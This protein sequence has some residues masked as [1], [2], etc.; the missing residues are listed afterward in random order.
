MTSLAEL[1]AD[2]WFPFTGS[3]EVKPLDP[4]VVPEPLRHGV[5]GVDCDGCSKPDE[6]FV[7]T[8]ERWRLS[9]YRESPFPGVVLLNTRAHFDSYADLTDDLLAELGPLTARVERAVLSIGDVARVHVARWGDG[10]EHFHQWFL[11]RPLGMLQARG[12]MLPMWLDLLPPLPPEAIDAALAQIAA[13]M[14]AS[15]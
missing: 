3:V 10:G 5:G 7:W 11:P 8:N 6:A 9:A 14:R 2:S 4:R 15:G 13:A 12:S 1:I